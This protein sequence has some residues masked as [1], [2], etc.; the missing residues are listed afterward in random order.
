MTIYQG[1]VVVPWVCIPIGAKPQLPAAL[2]PPKLGRVLNG[3]HGHHG[4]QCH[5]LR[6][7]E[8]TGQLMNGTSSVMRHH[9]IMNKCGANMFLVRILRLKYQCCL[10]VFH[11][12]RNLDRNLDLH[13][14]P[15]QTQAKSRSLK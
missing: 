14:N 9:Q 13:R 11:L 15:G 3:D 4:H 5:H 8:L 6:T 7:S 2:N 1:V 12:D 10:L